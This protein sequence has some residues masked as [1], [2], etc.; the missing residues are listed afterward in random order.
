MEEETFDEILN[1]LVRVYQKKK[2]YRFSIDS[3]LLAH[4]VSLKS[5]Q[6]LWISAAAAALFC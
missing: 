4:F 2:G 1:G 3:L 5:A 6:N